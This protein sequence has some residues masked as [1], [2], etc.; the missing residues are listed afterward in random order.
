MN[1]ILKNKNVL[2]IWIKNKEYIDGYVIADNIFYGVK[3]LFKK[4][5]KEFLG[6]SNVS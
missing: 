2:R 5:S 1:Y 4:R 3:F 6:I